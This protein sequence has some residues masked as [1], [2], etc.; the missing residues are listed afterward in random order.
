VPAPTIATVQPRRNFCGFLA[1]PE[2][3]LDAAPARVPPQKAAQLTRVI[4]A[5]HVYVEEEGKRSHMKAAQERQSRERFTD[6]RLRRSIATR[7]DYE[8]SPNIQENSFVETAKSPTN[9]RISSAIPQV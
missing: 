8:I 3:A 9:R 4:N 1:A 6:H 7:P 2:T 5:T